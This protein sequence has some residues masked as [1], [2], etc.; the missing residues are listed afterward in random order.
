[1][2]H[3]LHVSHIMNT[4]LSN[5]QS[6]SVGW[7]IVVGPSLVGSEADNIWRGLSF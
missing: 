5:A 2:E 6:K 3:L 1:M 7:E 4:I